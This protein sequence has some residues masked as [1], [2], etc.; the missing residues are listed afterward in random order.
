MLTWK[1]NTS[2]DLYSWKLCFIYHH[3]IANLLTLW[4][5]ISYFFTYYCYSG[6]IFF[7]S[8]ND[9]GGLLSNVPKVHNSQFYKTLPSRSKLAML[10]LVS[11]GEYRTQGKKRAPDQA[12]H[13]TSVG[14][15]RYMHVEIKHSYLHVSKKNT[16]TTNSCPK[17]KK[18]LTS[19]FK[20]QSKSLE[21]ILGVKT[22]QEIFQHKPSWTA[23]NEEDKNWD[24]N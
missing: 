20:E 16:Q 6:R 10:T 8:D 23:R 7:F 5:E 21:K 3:S 22:Q 2:I 17:H 18:M 19:Q 13:I 11:I 1:I 14:A 9:G 15:W 24:K 12:L 4:S